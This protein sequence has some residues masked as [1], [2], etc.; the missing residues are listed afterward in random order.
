MAS[1]IIR[2]TIEA[3]LIRFHDETVGSKAREHLPWWA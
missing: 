3:S 2:D 1:R